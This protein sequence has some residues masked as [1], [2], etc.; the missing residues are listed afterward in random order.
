MKR[1]ARWGR[2]TGQN[3]AH[4]GTGPCRACLE[5]TQPCGE[6][7]QSSQP[8][9]DAD[10]L[11][12]MVPD[13][14]HS[15]AKMSD[16]VVIDSV[17]Y[18]GYATIAPTVGTVSFTEPTST[19]TSQ[20]TSSTTLTSLTADTNVPTSTSSP[21]TSAT[22]T[23][24]ASAT[25]GQILTGNV[26]NI[27]WSHFAES[28]F[29][30]LCPTHDCVHDCQNYTR[31][32]EEVPYLITEP[33]NTYGKSINNQPPNITLFGLCSNL[34]NIY[35]GISENT[36]A[37]LRDSYFPI[38]SQDDVGLVSSTLATCL[39]TTCDYSR[40][41]QNCI[42]ACDMPVLYSGGA[43]TNLTAVTACLSMICGNTCGLP[44]A[45]QDVMGV[46]VSN[47][48]P[49]QVPANSIRGSRLVHHSSHSHHCMCNSFDLL[50]CLLHL[51]FS[52]EANT[53]RKYSTWTGRISGSSMLFHHCLGD[54]RIVLG[55]LEC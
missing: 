55:S 38:T 30:A 7:I 8:Y 39:A 4:D 24:T 33:F 13:E 44:Y 48:I 47:I 29:D 10:I 49:P 9:K 46:G 53:F 11:A 32:F 26:A 52:R 12:V 17:T 43:A 20:E 6:Q 51:S 18:S 34:A 16:A 15:A 35:D 27:P 1:E 2:A 25:Y 54:R 41:S 40:D 45:N 31:L 28:D 36:N 23:A 21:S 50:G 37:Q 22:A 5:P 19:S 42:A 14:S 3:S